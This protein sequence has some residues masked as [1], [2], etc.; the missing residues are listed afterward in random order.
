MSS[1]NCYWPLKKISAFIFKVSQHGF[2]PQKTL[3]C[4][5]TAVKTSKLTGAKHNPHTH[6]HTQHHTKSLPAAHDTRWGD[7]YLA[8]ILGRAISSSFLLRCSVTKVIFH[9]D[10]ILDLLLL[11]VI[12]V[13]C[14]RIDKFHE[15]SCLWLS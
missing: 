12:F 7:G 1:Y 14:E 9:L 15:C 8:L 11:F 6:T 3:Q 13:F 10:T 4:S 2:R 5:K